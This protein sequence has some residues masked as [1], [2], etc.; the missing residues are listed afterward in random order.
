MVMRFAFSSRW[1]RRTPSD[2]LLMR[3]LIGVGTPRGLRGRLV[4]V[5][6]T[7]LALTRGFWERVTPHRCLGLHIS[8]LE[9][10]AIIESGVMH[11]GA[12]EMVFT[13]GC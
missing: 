12:P 6:A 9:R 13:T 4:A 8:P 11:I 1:V 5:M 7:L 3:Q 2:G 10:H